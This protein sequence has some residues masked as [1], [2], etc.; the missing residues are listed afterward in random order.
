[1]SLAS[2]GFAFTHYVAATLTTHNA[3]AVFCFSAMVASTGNVIFLSLI[4]AIAPNCNETLGGSSLSI[5]AAISEKLGPKM[6]RALPWKFWLVAWCGI[7]RMSFAGL[8]QAAPFFLQT[9]RGLSAV[10]AN[11]L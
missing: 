4:T 2:L 3:V 6:I 10:E 9:H 5:K 1:M 11:R 8:V 7:L